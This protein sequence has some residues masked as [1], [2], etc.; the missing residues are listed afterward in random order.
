MKT[1]FLALIMGIT[2]SI[3]AHSGHFLYGCSQAYLPQF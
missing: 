2:L 1:S 3:S